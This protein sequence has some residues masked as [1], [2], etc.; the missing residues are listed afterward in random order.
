VKLVMTLLVRDEEDVITCNL[1]HHL[2]QGVDQVIV[3]DNRSVDGTSEILAE[4]AARGVV[5]VLK[6]L[7]DDFGQWRWVTRMARMAFE[8]GADWIVHADADEFWCAP[9]GWLP[10]VLADVP[11]QYGA[12]VAPRFNYP[13]TEDEAGV[14]YDRLVVRETL[15]L[16]AMGRPLP[17]KCCHRAYPDVQVAQ[18]NHEVRAEGMLLVPEPLAVDILHFPMRTFKGFERRIMV[19]GQAYARN[20]E[21]PDNVG[22]TWRRLYAL[23]ERGELRDYWDGQV[24]TQEHASE[25]LLSGRLRVDTRVRDAA[26]ARSARKPLPTKKQTQ[27]PGGLILT[28]NRPRSP[29]KGDPS[30]VTAGGQ[31]AVPEAVDRLDNVELP[32]SGCPQRGAPQ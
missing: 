4:Y 30:L 21:L 29:E 5:R 9:S 22:D 28:A 14:F 12:A 19:G 11:R 3:T 27:A 26:R 31:D 25:R 20:R 24:L 16:N 6:E 10:D 18:G 13:P 8:G 17:G 7:A 32:R 1:D 23:Y 15:S 2:D